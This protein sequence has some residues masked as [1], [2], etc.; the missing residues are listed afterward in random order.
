MRQAKWDHING[1]ITQEYDKARKRF[2]SYVK[3]FKENIGITVIKKDGRGATS[4]QQKDEM[5]NAQFSSV[6][7]EED[8][9]N[10]P[11]IDKRYPSRSI[12][13]VSAVGVEKLLLNLNASKLL[14][15]TT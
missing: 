8:I 3:Q 13:N 6:F 7:T 10:L 5:R 2:L 14:D 15:L 1:I 11:Q 9:R 4:P 12:L